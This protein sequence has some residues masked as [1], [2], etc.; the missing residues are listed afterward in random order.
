MNTRGL[1]SAGFFTTAFDLD[2]MARPSFVSAT[3]LEGIAALGAYGAADG[4]GH[5]ARH[6]YSLLRRAIV[7]C[8]LAPGTALN[9]AAVAEQL[10]LSRSP[11]REAFRSLSADGLVDIVPQKGTFVSLLERGAL[12]DALFVREAIECA[13]VRLAAQAPLPDRQILSRIV[14]RHRE[15]LRF[16]DREAS[17]AAD[18][19]FHRSIVLLAGHASAWSVV[20]TARTRLERLRRLAN[21]AIRG[22]EEAVVFHD[23]IA[24]A[25]LDGD[26]DLA[27]RVLREHI[28]QVKGFIDRLADIYPKYLA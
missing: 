22:S 8:T 23:K 21:K 14:E 6:V 25:V 3:T 2:G 24:A 15:A 13:A 27:E 4:R 12:I 9:E 1:E 7:E 5:A 16:D 11:I 18:E 26:A 19:D 10:G 28:R 20:L 17:L